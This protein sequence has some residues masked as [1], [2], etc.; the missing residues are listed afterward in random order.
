MTTRTALITGVSRPLGLGFAVA[1]QLA[2]RDHHVILTARNAAQ[3]E[4]LATQLRQDNL[5]A[6]ALPL[7]LTDRAGMDDIATH[8]ARP[9]DHLDV[10]I[11]NASAFPD[12]GVLSA[13]DADLDAVRAALEV[14]VIG[15][16]GLIQT[17]LPLL[18]KAPAARIVNVSSI[19]ALQ[20]T[21]GLHLAARLR[22]PGHS[23]AKYLLTVLTA[24]L[25]DELRD[26]AILVNAVDPGETASHP[27][28]G[29][30]D[31]TRP[32]ADSA[33]GVVWAAT[34]GDDGPSGGFFRDGHPLT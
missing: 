33:R 32:A 1:R 21:A 28:R 18:R 13:L 19:A 9:F 11:N 17:M 10:L 22:A 3:A 25:A 6:T 4:Q 20:I 16:W 5:Q 27:E 24:K 23:F 34:L 29:D 2:E 31:D 26:T 15:P 8:L 30:E 12:A 14:D 7:D